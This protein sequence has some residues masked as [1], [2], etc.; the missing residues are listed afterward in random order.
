MKYKLKD[1]VKASDIPRYSTVSKQIAAVLS[2]C[3]VV[4]CDDM[5]DTL[6][7]MV[8]EVVEAPKKVKENK[9]EK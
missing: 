8:E 7:S 1:G 3:K 6:L 9:G 2:K 5:P 4:E